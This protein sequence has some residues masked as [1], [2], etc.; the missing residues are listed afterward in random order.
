MA[1]AISSRTL[2]VT[3]L[4]AYV[5]YKEFERL[6]TQLR[7]CSS[8]HLAKANNGALFGVLEFLDVESAALAHS[9]YNGYEGWDTPGLYIHP[10]PL[11][12]PN[13]ANKRPL[14][15][16]DAEGPPA[17]QARQAAPLQNGLGGY[18]AGVVPALAGVSQPLMPPL[19]AELPVGGAL[20]NGAPVTAL[21]NGH[22]AE[23][24][25]NPLQLPD[26]AQQPYQADIYSEDAMAA[27]AY[28]EYVQQEILPGADGIAPNDTLYISN[29]PQDVTKRELA[30]IFR[31]FLGFTNCRLLRPQGNKQNA[32]VHF[33][34]TE[35]AA[36]ARTT[37]DNYP[38]DLE[39]LELYCL[40][41]AFAKPK[42]TREPQRGS[43][44]SASRERQTLYPD[45]ARGGARGGPGGARGGA[46]SS[47]RSA[48]TYGRDESLRGRGGGH[49]RPR[50]PRPS[51][52]RP[53]R[54]SY[55]DDVLYDDH[56]PPPHYGGPPDPRLHS[57]RDAHGPIPHGRG[58]PMSR[59]GRG[60]GSPRGR[61]GPPR[62]SFGGRGDPHRDRPS[63]R[64][65]YH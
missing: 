61:H 5:E 49:A 45:P 33:D 62:G 4:P 11:T 1:S 34:T 37:L 14:E 65:G 51:S 47:G 19:P 17:K 57:R 16:G 8:C 18:D 42:K 53:E 46:P 20:P 39:D 28:D 12:F 32:V 23:E 36:H 30:H 29:L 55:D 38:M 48:S 63:S 44:R 21:A 25:Y 27:A 52:S 7:G 3:N 50:A 41:V 2:L 13:N 15:G 31:P 22:Y 60:G 40:T 58:G 26:G 59:G 6:F 64:G 43:L 10:P 24:P 56:A 9:I 54:H 35:N